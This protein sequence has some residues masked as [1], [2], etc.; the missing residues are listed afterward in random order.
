MATEP[1]LTLEPRVKDS[2][3][4]WKQKRLERKP[5]VAVSAVEINQ[6]ES[7]SVVE[8]VQDR[9]SETLAVQSP[10]QKPASQLDEEQYSSEEHIMRQN[11][12]IITPNRSYQL[13][14]DFP[15]SRKLAPGEVMIRNKAAGLNHI[16]WKSVEYNFCLPELPWVTGREMAGV[17]EHV[18]PGVT[19]LKKGDH[20]WTST[21]YRDRR[22]G[23]FQDL[24]VVPEHTVFSIPINLDFHTAAILGVAGLTA[25]M[26][27]WK[28]LRIPMHTDSQDQQQEPERE[29]MLVWGGSTATGQFA[30]QLAERAGI[31]VIAVCSEATTQLVTSL[32][33]THVVAYTNKTDPQII[34]EIVSL[35][36]G[37][38]TKAID[39]VG[40]T[41]AKLVLQVITACSDTEI[42]FA[43]VAYMSSKEVVP[44]NARVHIVEMKQFVMDS[45]CGIY[46]ERLNQLIEDGAIKI[47]TVSVLKGGL[48]AVEDGLRLVKEG[49]LAGRKLVVS[50]CH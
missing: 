42:D 8:T 6:K 23:C 43:P 27:L 39:L 22:A 37:R 12:L 46:G 14:T 18:G 38:L 7:S 1:V 48:S 13:I 10:A 32:G 47:P 11:A 15:V 28:W 36:R 34:D 45:S 24:V 3:G 9:Q 25:A 21:Y 40:A 31:E 20:V 50:L 4:F 33:A 41:T 5:L 2:R 16:D 17:V 49:N 19:R 44:P 29:V 30:I 26:T 35:A